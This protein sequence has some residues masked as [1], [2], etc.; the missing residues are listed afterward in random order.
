MPRRQRYPQQDFLLDQG[1]HF[2]FLACHN[3]VRRI[4]RARF[5]RGFIG[6]ELH[7]RVY[8]QGIFHFHQATLAGQ[9]Q[10]PIH[11]NMQ[12]GFAILTQ[13]AGNAVTHRAR[14]A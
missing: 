2:H 9:R 13:T 4:L 12:E 14:A 5:E 3:R 10:A 6:D 11:G 1:R 7:F 8:R